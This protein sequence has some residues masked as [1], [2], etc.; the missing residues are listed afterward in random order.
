MPITFLN[1]A[2]KENKSKVNMLMKSNK[3]KNNISL[4]SSAQTKENILMTSEGVRN[5][6]DG[7]QRRH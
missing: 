3:C 2:K 5:N 1:K 7:A 6:A 4:G